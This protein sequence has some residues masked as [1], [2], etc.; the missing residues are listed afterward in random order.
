MSKNPRQV[1]SNIQEKQPHT[2]TKHTSNISQSFIILCQQIANTSL[3]FCFF[4]NNQNAYFS[5]VTN[6][7]K[8]EKILIFLLFPYNLTNLH[9]CLFNSLV[10]HTALHQLHKKYCCSYAE[11]NAQQQIIIS[12]Q[13]K[14]C[15]FNPCKF[16]CLSEKNPSIRPQKL[17]K[18]VTAQVGE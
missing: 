7:T 15:F 16:F 8:V 12:C 4:F 18:S 14:P 10:L 2:A 1:S 6:C 17:K 9:S 5:S 13:K 3:H 11:T